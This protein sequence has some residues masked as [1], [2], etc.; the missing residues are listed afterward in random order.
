MISFTDYY[1]EEHK[2]L[3][4]RCKHQS[5]DILKVKET[6]LSFLV[7]FMATPSEDG[8]INLENVEN[9]FVLPNSIFI[10]LNPV[11]LHN[12]YYAP[13]LGY[14]CLITPS[15][16]DKNLRSMTGYMVADLFE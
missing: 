2:S 3:L 8:R 6:N 7:M 4:M 14:H 15:K 11:Y 16:Q 10:L 1:I 12:G 9:T 13:T 5:G